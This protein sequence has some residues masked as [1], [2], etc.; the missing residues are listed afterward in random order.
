MNNNSN[1]FTKTLKKEKNETYSDTIND[2][3]HQTSH[4]NE[5]FEKGLSKISNISI[6]NE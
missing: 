3:I 2:M 4:L 1:L 5:V 6:K